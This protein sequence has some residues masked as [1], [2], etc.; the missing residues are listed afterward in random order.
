MTWTTYLAD[1]VLNH[2]FRNVAL[3]S[4]TTVYLSL[5][6][7]VTDKEAGTVTEATFT[8]Y[9][10]Q[11]V[12]FGAPSAVNGARRIANTGA[13]TFPAK[14]DAGTATI[15]ACGVHDAVS[16]GN[17]GQIILLHGDDPL[18]FVSDVPASDTLMYPAH[19]LASNQRVRLETTPGAPTLPAP[20]AENTD[21]YV[22]TDT[23][24]TFK[25]SASAG[26]GG[27]VD[28]TAEG[29]G[30]L[31]KLTPLLLNQNDQANFAIG[32]LKVYLD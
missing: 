6:T 17:L 3:T 28:I 5:L 22:I 8:N 12:T 13:I 4:P 21:Y 7:A 16:A 31:T 26:P 1:A 23:A 9:A 30:I 11:A 10:R 18:D 20:L 15:I 24:D 25:L 14:G 19:G 29:A 2:W 27:A 32:T